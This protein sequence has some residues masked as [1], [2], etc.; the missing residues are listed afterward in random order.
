MKLMSLSHLT[1]PAFDSSI[2]AALSHEFS[3]T[4]LVLA[5]L[6]EADARRRYLPLGYAS[7]HLYCIGSLHMSEDVAFKR[8]AAARAVRRFPVLLEA[9]GDGRLTLSAVVLLAPHLSEETLGELMTAAQYRTSAEVRSLVAG[10]FPQRSL[11]P[12]HTH[13]PAPTASSPA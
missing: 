7:M 5:H 8:I 2:T 4:A 12:R 6:V 3:A 11:A 10:R 13:I 1:D 9:I